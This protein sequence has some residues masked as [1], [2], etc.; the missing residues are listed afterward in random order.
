MI[1]N[2]KV[3]EQL[4]KGAFSTVFKG[5][6]RIHKTPVALKVSTEKQTHET[7]ILAYLNREL[8]TSNL[9]IPTLYWY[10]LFGNNTCIAT[11]FYETT[12][13]NYVDTV[14][15]STTL[16]DPV[17]KIRGMCEQLICAIEKIH[18]AHIVHSDIKPDN[19]MVNGDRV[20]VIDFGLSSLV[21]NIENAVHREN[22]KTEHLIGSPKFASYNL[23]VGNTVSYR[24]DLISMGYMMMTMFRI[25]IPWANLVSE[26]D[27][28]CELPLYHV[29]H[30]LNIRRARQKH[31]KNIRQ[32]LSS[33]PVVS[34]WLLPF[35]EEIYSLEYGEKPAYA[36]YVKELVRS[37]QQKEGK[38]QKDPG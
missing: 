16:C 11:T 3:I 25:D 38:D 35:L 29:A 14:W 24:D 17:E 7:K 31:I 23:H 27:D 26:E 32:S 37:S 4:G 34:Q 2:Y 21:Y 20:F 5:V 28:E 36:K 33:V 10:G 8:A 22:K 13:Q 6:H 30:P 9:C 1:H 15:N 18:S 12:F 19:F